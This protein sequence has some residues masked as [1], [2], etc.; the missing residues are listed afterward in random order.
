MPPLFG[1]GKPAALPSGSGTFIVASAAVAVDTNVT[2]TAPSAVS[3]PTV[4]RER[5][6]MCMRIPLLVGERGTV[7]VGL[8]LYSD[9]TRTGVASDRQRLPRFG[10]ELPSFLTGDG[11]PVR[12]AAGFA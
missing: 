7:P 2:S 6:E 9:R 4:R 8:F 10:G 12:G 1:D 3:S 5:V 11:E